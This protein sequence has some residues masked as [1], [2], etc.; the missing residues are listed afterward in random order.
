[1]R[2]TKS[3][4]PFALL[5][6]VALAGRPAAAQEGEHG[7][8]RSEGVA[9]PR[10]RS[11]E[12]RRAPSAEAPRRTAATPV[13]SRRAEASRA[14]ARAANES[15]GSGRSPNVYQRQEDG[16]AVPR[17]Q[18][19]APRVDRPVVV[20]PRVVRPVIV[21]PRVYA[22]RHYYGGYYGYRPGFRPYAFRPWTRLSFGFFVGYPVPYVYSYPYPVPV[23]GYGAPSAPVYITPSSTLYGGVT[24]EIS[25]RDA[26][27]FVDGQY[28]GQVR[29][30]DGVGAP[31]NLTVGRHRVDVSAPGY[32]PL[33]FDVDVRPGQLVPYRGDMHPILY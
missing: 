27:V 32:E 21:A 26:E 13:E 7:H 20:A 30:F 23:Y 29:D 10:D 9:V 33:W 6:I 25:P 3:F 14:D 22:P 28:V 2:L 18:V 11:S 4:K 15:R 17:P 19:V 31:L 16:R 5:A 8:G 24:L 1:M 12:T